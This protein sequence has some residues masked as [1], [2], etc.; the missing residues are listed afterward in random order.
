MIEG[1]GMFTLF[2]QY[3]SFR[4][5]E[6]PEPMHQNAQETVISNVVRVLAYRRQLEAASW[7]SSVVV[8]VQVCNAQGCFSEDD[9]S[10]DTHVLVITAPIDIYY[11][12]MNSLDD[13]NS[14]IRQ[15][16]EEI[17]SAFSEFNFYISFIDCELEMVEPPE[18]WRNRLR[19]FVSRF[20]VTPNQGIFNY[21]N[22]SKLVHR[23]LN[24][25]SKT[26]IK[27]FDTLVS[28]KLLVLPLPVA[29]MGSDND[30][31]EPDLVVIYKGKAGILDVQGESFH[32]PQTAAKEHE[33]RRRFTQLG[34][35]VYEIFDATRCWND[36]ERVVDD[37]LKAFDS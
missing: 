1:V 2:H 4:Y 13:E 9:E 37:F 23:Q 6:H 19:D 35:Q 22:S 12:L 29:V 32:P 33:R 27:I 14:S 15:T 24:F 5:Y 21:Q 11:Y 17:A 10:F 7:L 28:R 16:F 3:Q 34:I 20:D 8:D 31:L 30:Y 18:D 36:P 25:R 26:E